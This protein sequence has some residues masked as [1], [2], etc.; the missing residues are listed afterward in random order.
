MLEDEATPPPPPPPLGGGVI[1]DEDS[2]STG[3]S[4]SIE[5]RRSRKLSSRLINV[6]KQRPEHQDQL[7]RQ[8][9]YSTRVSTAS[10]NTTTTTATISP[11]T[12]VTPVYGRDKELQSLRDAFDRV[13]CS[14][15]PSSELVVVHGPSG[16]GKSS[17]VHHALLL[18]WCREERS[19]CQVM[20]GCGKYDQLETNEPFAAIVA[21]SNQLCDQ[22]AQQEESVL[23]NFT[24]TLCKLAGNNDDVQVLANALPGLKPLLTKSSSFSNR[25]DDRSSTTSSSAADAQFLVLSQAFT[26]FKQLWRSFLTSVTTIG[27]VTVMFL[28][29]VHWADSNSLDLIHSLTSHESMQSIR[30]LLVCAYRNDATLGEAQQDALLWS[31]SLDKIFDED[32][33]PLNPEPQDDYY[34]NNNNDEEEEEEEEKRE[35]EEDDGDDYD[36]DNDN[37]DDDDDDDKEDRG[38]VRV[39]TNVIE[40]SNLGP[41][42][43]NAL[44]G[45]I[46]YGRASSA[47]YCRDL[48][49]V[50][51]N[52]TS[53]NPFFAFLYLD[54]LTLLNLL[55]TDDGGKT[56][57][58]DVDLIIGQDNVP[59][60]IP[61]LLRNIIARIPAEMKTVLVTAAHIGHEFSS[62]L[63]EQETLFQTSDRQLNLTKRK[64]LPA[65][66]ST[67]PVL[68]ERTW[69][70]LDAAVHEGLLER[71][72][73]HLY[74]FPHDQI[75]NT[76]YDELCD[77]PVEQAR[78]HLK[79]GR[80]LLHLTEQQYLAEVPTTTTTTTTGNVN[81]LGA[82]N[83][84]DLFVAVDNLNQGSHLII[85]P[86]ERTELVR[87]NFE[88][89]QQA[90]GRSAFVGAL[91]Y[92]RCGISLL[93]KQRWQ[94]Q[95]DLCLDL[96]S[97]AARLEYCTGNFDRSNVLIAEIHKN[98]KSIID[99]LPGYFTEIDVLQ[100]RGDL[101]EALELGVRVVREL[102]EPLP[103]RC[104]VGHVLWEY[105]W[106]A[107]AM[108]KAK[109][110]GFLNLPPVT[111]PTHVATMTVLRSITM[112]SSLIGTESMNNYAVAIL[113]ISRLCCRYGLSEYLPFGVT[114]FA[115]VQGGLGSF[116]EAYDTAK[117]AMDLLDYVDGS[118]IMAARIWV[119]IHG[120]ISPWTGMA[121]VEVH[122]EFLRSYH[123]GMAHGD[124]EYA[125]FGAVNYCC[126]ALLRGSPLEE[127]ED[128]C[129]KYVMEM[130]EFQVNVQKWL[131]I[132][133]WESA[134]ALIGWRA[135]RE[136]NEALY[137]MNLIDEM[138]RQTVPG[139]IPFGA[140]FGDVMTK[141][142]LG[143]FGRSTLREDE[144]SLHILDST[145]GLVHTH[146]IRMFSTLLLGMGS[147][148]LFRQT[149]K[150]RHRRKA[151]Q[152]L[153]ITRK[154]NKKSVT[155]AIPLYLLLLAEF[156][157]MKAK[158]DAES[159][160]QR[161]TKDLTRVQDA[162][163][164]AAA[165]AASGR[166]EC[167]MVAAYCY[168]RLAAI[169]TK[170]EGGG[171]SR[172]N[173]FL[174]RAEDIYT[175]WGASAKV[176]AIQASYTGSFTAATSI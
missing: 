28:D 70:V 36:D 98:G 133:Y 100:T 139:T 106:A 23:T 58:W 93:S 78:L 144:H 99:R 4:S 88:A 141:L 67:N 32:N 113:R 120:M 149:G 119:P 12:S 30:L 65:Q 163:L 154:W 71:K 130:E 82:E 158:A 49:N 116:S 121:L 89:S 122:G 73:K 56:W 15:D 51:L 147:F 10:N 13:V 29:D 96:Y 164:E 118:H 92:A 20:V 171:R 146:Y 165:S 38:V 109:K 129:R 151:R 26:R 5:R 123:V 57:E 80:T 33:D 50:V 155:S 94:T 62:I 35:E 84:R 166:G 48:S 161:H 60:T 83:A 157:A 105:F 167:L 126:V 110:Q 19:S 8:S 156:K 68:R 140:K 34:N 168:E 175:K 90:L 153:K 59:D 40:L 125:Y 6:L 176:E 21:A 104:G 63:L 69:A 44:V 137:A 135:C 14:K 27:N 11:S 53:G 85:N 25:L 148:E 24:K 95:Y 103:L 31:L 173:T 77:Q 81:N 97:L 42:G 174:K 117:L 22:I 1:S 45:G 37:D 47:S 91:E 170:Q 52:H 115:S 142:I 143:T 18:D 132:G 134:L 152:A 145:V 43:M 55:R 16:S 76:L 54:Y 46:L 131:V 111:D 87:L 162:Y 159:S 39:K 7:Q 108:K 3:L 150:R 172:A 114:A 79:I 112:S 64:I 9:S 169:I 102:G 160:A 101:K 107:R 86:L 2:T 72:S 75:Q 17:L 128:D 66:P 127:L 136:S 41:D 138:K 124:I 74:A 61:D